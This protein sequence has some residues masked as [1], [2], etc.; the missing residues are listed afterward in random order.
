[1]KEPSRRGLD[2][3]RSN[4]EF[5]YLVSSRARP[6]NLLSSDVI[7][8]HI[9]MDLPQSVKSNRTG[10]SAWFKPML[11]GFCRNS[12]HTRTNASRP[13]NIVLIELSHYK[14]RGIFLS[15]KAERT[16]NEM[17]NFIMY[18]FAY[19]ILASLQL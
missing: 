16:V 11:L 3:T 10:Q 8:G 18:T 6:F 17:E 2:F 5:L 12:R 7:S 13:F 14:S 4:I 9:L 19:Y 1:M 15:L